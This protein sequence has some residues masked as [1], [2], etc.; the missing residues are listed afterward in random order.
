MYIS[1]DHEGFNCKTKCS[2]FLSRNVIT[3]NAKKEHSDYCQ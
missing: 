1:F 3:L 2:E